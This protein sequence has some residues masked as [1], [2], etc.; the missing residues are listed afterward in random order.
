M[1]QEPKRAASRSARKPPVFYRGSAAQSDSR[2]SAK[3]SS[4]NVSCIRSVSSSMDIRTEIIPAHDAVI[5]GDPSKTRC[6]P[7]LHGHRVVREEIIPA[8]VANSSTY[9]LLRYH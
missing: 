4:S 3:R 8:C 7:H 2:A 6:E 9:N 5:C 1:R